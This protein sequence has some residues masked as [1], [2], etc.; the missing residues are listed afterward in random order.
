MRLALV[1]ALI[2]VVYEKY[3]SGRPKLVVKIAH[4]PESVVLLRYADAAGANGKIVDRDNTGGRPAD[5]QLKKL[6]GPKKD[7]VVILGGHHG[8]HGLVDRV[9]GEKLVRIAD[10]FGDAA[11]LDGDSVPEIITT[12]EVMSDEPCSPGESVTISHWNGTRFAPDGRRYVASLSGD[13]A[14]M[15]VAFSATKHYKLHLF[16]PGRVSVEGSRPLAPGY[17]F[18]F[19][20]GCHT[21]S[22]RGGTTKTHAFLEELP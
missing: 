19:A 4:D 22:L 3:P 17:P 10:D 13:S 8:D 5:V 1:L 20:A 6:A 12:T 2:S 18:E 11:D 15:D 7:V 21:L 16:G 14:E 9:A